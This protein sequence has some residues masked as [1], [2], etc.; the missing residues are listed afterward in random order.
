MKEKARLNAFAERLAER[1][2]EVEE[3]K[4]RLDQ[5]VANPP[6][7]QKGDF[8]KVT[9]TLPPAVYQVLNEEVVRRKLA[10]EPNPRMSAVIREAVVAFLAGR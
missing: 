7:G 1:P 5:L 8:V 2:H 6:H 4:S 10:K 3:V 9:V